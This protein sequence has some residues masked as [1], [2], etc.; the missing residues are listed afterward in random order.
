M[1]LV[2]PSTEN[3]DEYRRESSTSFPVTRVQESAPELQYS[4]AP[5]TQAIIHSNSTDNAIPKLKRKG[6]LGNLKGNKKKNGK[7]KA[8][9]NI[10]DQEQGMIVEA[11]EKKISRARLRQERLEKTERKKQKRLE[12]ALKRQNR[13]KK[14]KTTPAS[15]IEDAFTTE[16]YSPHRLISSIEILEYKSTS[17][18]EAPITQYTDLALQEYTPA[19]KPKKRKHHNSVYTTE[20]SISEAQVKANK[21]MKRKHNNSFNDNLVN[22]TNKENAFGD[23]RMRDSA[24][25]VVNAFVDDVVNGKLQTTTT[26]RPLVTE[27]FL[28]Q[29]TMSNKISKDD[30]WFGDLSCLNPF[31]LAPES[32]GAHIT[33][34][35]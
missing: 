4:T 32:I 11:S 20:N 21:S 25:F 24:G 17:T 26:E 5:R 22:N 3:F 34:R 10:E 16:K 2:S 19:S 9:K 28:F 35:R 6:K 14:I 30:V 1:P 15:E 27:S 33:Y 13:R 8:R 29:T 7:K 18:T 23:E 12:L 31:I